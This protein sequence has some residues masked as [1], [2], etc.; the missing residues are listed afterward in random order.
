ML[1][2]SRQQQLAGTLR[3]RHSIIEQGIDPIG[4]KRPNNSVKKASQGSVVSGVL[5]SPSKEKDKVITPPERKR[6]DISCVSSNVQSKISHIWGRCSDTF[7]KR[8]AIHWPRM[9]LTA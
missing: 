1:A 6:H 4:I 7:T 5:D 2:G 9:R 3:K 8:I